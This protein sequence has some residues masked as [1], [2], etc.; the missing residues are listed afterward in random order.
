MSWGTRDDEGVNNTPRYRGLR[1]EA[2]RHAAFVRLKTLSR[3]V[4]DRTRESAV[5]L[6]AQSMTMAGL[7]AQCDF[8][9]VSDKR[10]F[11]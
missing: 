6:P 2:K 7:P 8:D 9:S 3:S 1:R 10:V 4:I 11:G 5:A